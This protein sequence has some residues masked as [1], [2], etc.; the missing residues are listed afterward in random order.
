MLEAKV[1]GAVIRCF[2]DYL[3]IEKTGMFGGIAFDPN[4]KF[5]D[6]AELGHKKASHMLNGFIHISTFSPDGTF[7]TVH[8]MSEMF[9]GNVKNFFNYTVKQGENLLPILDHINNWLSVNGSGP[10][11]KSAGKV[12]K[13]TQAK[14]LKDLFDAG[15]ISQA[16]F[17]IQINQLK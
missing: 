9:Q 5:S 13:D 1:S 8:K 17:E 11:I 15:L 4:I 14:A 3:T 10:A 6:I 2:D 7:F 16:D 12:D